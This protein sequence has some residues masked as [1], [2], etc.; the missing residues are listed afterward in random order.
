MSS[1]SGDFPDDHRKAVEAGCVQMQRDLQLFLTG[2]LRSRHLVEDAWQRTVILALQSAHSARLGTLRGWLFQIALNEARR[3]L[4]ENR[5]LPAHTDP[6][7]LANLSA[8]ASTPASHSSQA[9]DFRAIHEETRSVVQECLKSLPPEQQEVIRQRIYHG[10]T[11]TEIAAD[12][13]LPLGTVLTWCRR[14]ILRL[15]T[16]PRLKDLMKD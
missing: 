3:I 12:L 5:K 15:K 6:A 1:D 10:R 13:Q 7:D 4:R 9:P 8:A 14:G 11:F 16:D 2:I